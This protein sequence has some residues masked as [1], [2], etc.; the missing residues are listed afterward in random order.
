MRTPVISNGWNDF[1]APW[2]GSVGGSDVWLYVRLA[3]VPSKRLAPS[4]RWSMH[5]ALWQAGSELPDIS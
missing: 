4:H 1:N 3:K 2:V 5:A